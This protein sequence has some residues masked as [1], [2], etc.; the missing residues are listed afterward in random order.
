M[1]NDF[2]TPKLANENI[3]FQ[4][5]RITRWFSDISGLS[6]TRL[7]VGDISAMVEISAEAPRPRG[8]TATGR[9]CLGAARCP[10]PAA[11]AVVPRQRAAGHPR[12][13]IPGNN[14]FLLHV[15]VQST[16]D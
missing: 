9:W 2:D 15:A 1:E 12:E 4:M 16:S 6:T 11:E 10:L 7:L 8:T 3:G 14:P 13:T 5:R